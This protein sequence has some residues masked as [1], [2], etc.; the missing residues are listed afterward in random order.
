LRTYVKSEIAARGPLRSRDLEDRS[1]SA[2][3]S[4][5][6]THGRNVSLMLEF[7]SARGEIAVAGRAGNE[8]LWDLAERV[9]PADIGR[10][11]AREAEGQLARR[12]LKSLGL[13]RPNHSGDIGVRA[14]V[15]GLPGGWLVDPEVLDLPFEG[16]TAILSPF[17][18]LIYDRR[19]ALELFG[20]DYRLEIYV[21]PAK[22]RWGYYVLPVLNGDRLVAK[23][24]AKADRDAG[25]LR[26]PS[27]YLEAGATNDDARAVQTEL[28]T[29]A[30][31]LGLKRAVIGRRVREQRATS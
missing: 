3:H 8:R 16:R 4:S 22:R 31:W 20:F 24:D 30:E 12:R 23:V 2:W 13:A 6:W 25:V 27:L 29:L 14:S 5:G 18:R 9:L 1:V 15:E 10:I 28:N 21:P 11:S 19:R 7:L 26:I 17:D